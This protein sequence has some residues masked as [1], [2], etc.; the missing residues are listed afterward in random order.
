MSMP[1]PARKPWLRSTSTVTC[2]EDRSS[3]T[4]R[5]SVAAAPIRARDHMPTSSPARKLSVAKV[6]STS[7]GG[8]KGVSSAMT[9]TP[10]CR[11]RPTEPSRAAGSEGVTKMPC[12]LGEQGLDG[13]NLR[14]GIS[15]VEPCERAQLDTEFTGSPERT[16]LHLHEERV[17]VGLRDQTHRQIASSGS[18]RLDGDI[19]RRG[20][21]RRAASSDKDSAGQSRCRE[22]ADGAQ[23]S[24]SGFALHGHRE[25]Q[26]EPLVVK[27]TR[28]DGTL[29]VGA[30]R[31]VAADG[32]WVFHDGDGRPLAAL[33]ATEVDAIESVPEDDA[34][35]R[36]WRHPPVPVVR[37]AET[38]RP[39]SGSSWG[40]VV[41]SRGIAAGRARCRSGNRGL[42]VRGLTPSLPARRGP[43]SG[44]W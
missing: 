1:K 32:C 28:F 13:P 8:S 18:A 4:I 23:A 42:E 38:R 24:L 12:A 37:Q 35:G 6:A 41:G 40:L 25:K 11:A 27:R 26:V 43:H 15:V 36:A 19:R 30:R 2:T 10:A 34:R 29:V 39:R 9:S 31:A 16:L 17:G 33:P 7:F 20:G 44:G 14:L 3:V 21:R 22:D 5:A